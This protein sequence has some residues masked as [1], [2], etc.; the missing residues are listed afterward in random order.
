MFAMPRECRL[1]GKQA[2]TILEKVAEAGVSR[3]QVKVAMKAMSFAYQLQKGVESQNFPKVTSTWHTLGPFGKPVRQM[4]PV[5]IPQP[6]DLKEAFTKN[7]SPNCGLPLATWLVGQLAAWDWSVCGLRTNVDMRKVKLSRDHEVNARDGYSSSGFHEGRAK[8]PKQKRGTRCWRVWRLCLCEGGKHKSPPKDVE[9]N[10]DEE[11]NLRS[12][13]PGWDTCCP[14]AAQELVMRRQPEGGVRLYAKWGRKRR[15]FTKDSHC[16]PT[17][18]ANEWFQCQ[19]IESAPF[20]SNAGRKSLA[21]WL[22]LG[23]EKEMDVPYHESVQIHG[24]LFKVWR[25]NYQPD[26]CNPT[27]YKGREQ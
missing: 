2:A 19:G 13:E 22:S 9:Y 21:L 15:R 5:R 14:V 6:Q 25:S 18:L 12:G 1:T 7:W 11:G 24:D 26:V 23:K 10:F 3:E 17:K 8:L 4:K 27:G 16:F 20:D